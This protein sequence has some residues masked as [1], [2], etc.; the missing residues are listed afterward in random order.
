MMNDTAMVSSTVRS[1]P[2]HDGQQSRLTA[3]GKRQGL[4]HRLRMW[5]KKRAK[6]RLRIVSLNVGTVTEKSR[7]LADM[8]DRRRLDIACVQETQ[9]KGSNPREIRD[10]Y[11]LLSTPQ[12]V[13][14]IGHRVLSVSK[15]MSPSNSVEV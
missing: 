9:W 3:V 8:L 4:S 7:E 11:K 13:L 2:V 1:S 10:V 15:K 12:T 5:P 14:Q 6:T